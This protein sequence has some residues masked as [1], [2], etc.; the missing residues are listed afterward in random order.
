MTV[1][2]MHQCRIQKW[3][4]ILSLLL[5]LCNIKPKRFLGLS[6]CFYT[7]MDLSAPPLNQNPEAPLTEPQRSGEP[8]RRSKQRSLRPS[9]S[10]QESPDNC[11]PPTVVVVVGGATVSA[12]FTST[13][14]QKHHQLSFT[15][16]EPSRCCWWLNAESSAMVSIHLHHRFISF[17]SNI[18]GDGRTENEARFDVGVSPPCLPF[19]LCVYVCVGGGL[20]PDS[21]VLC[22]SEG[23]GGQ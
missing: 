20:Q 2:S 12:S 18:R 7:L 22:H 11:R 14:C 3:G 13:F 21:A 15:S 10:T 6:R 16:A 1:L 5:P 4:E 9:V 17:Y 23:A 8:S 19:F